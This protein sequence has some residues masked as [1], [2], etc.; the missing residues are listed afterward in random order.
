VEQPKGTCHFLG[1]S[2]RH[3][4]AI[5]AVV[6]GQFVGILIT[7]VDVSFAGADVGLSAGS[8]EVQRIGVVRQ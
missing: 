5:I 8:S 4:D 2:T 6:Y 3:P 1:S 7:L